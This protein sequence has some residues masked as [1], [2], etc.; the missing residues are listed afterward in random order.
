MAD[1]VETFIENVH[2]ELERILGVVTPNDIGAKKRPWNR[3]APHVLWVLGEIT[4]GFADDLSDTTKAFATEFQELIIRCW[5]SDYESCRALKNAVLLACRNVAGGPQ[6][7]FGTFRWGT[8]DEPGQ[9][10][11]GVTLIGSVTL[12]LALPADP[13]GLQQTVI[14]TGLEHDVFFDYPQGGSEDVGC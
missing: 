14:I 12:A 10:K 1:V 4:H 11:N 6:L 5:H 7:Q 13:T 8:E 9:I 2:T 3:S